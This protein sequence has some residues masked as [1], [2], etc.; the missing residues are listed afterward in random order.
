MRKPVAKRSKW[1]RI[2]AVSLVL[3]MAA[4]AGTAAY[5]YRLLTHRVV[6]SFFDSAGARIHYTD[7]GKG[8][9]VILLHGFAVHSDINWRHPGVIAELSK[10]FRVISMDLR[11]HG[12]S[13][14]PHEPAQYGVNLAEDVIRLMD[15]VGVANAHVVGYSLGGFVALKVAV[16]HPDRV[17]TVSPLGAGWETAD[18]STFL[19]SL[20]ELEASLRTGRGI[21][22][23]SGSLGPNRAKPG[24]L[25]TLFVK[26]MTR[27]FADSQALSALVSTVPALT[28]AEDELRAIQVPVCSIIGSDDPLKPGVDAMVGKVSDHTVIVLG[29]VDHLRAPSS[30]ELRARL[31]EFLERHPPGGQG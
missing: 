12:L 3:L 2:T 14:K 8:V 4:A 11:G 21:A 22:P 18:S 29:G 24:P 10:H 26:I 15:H 7:E 23:L 20:P 30:P 19:R 31:V 16:L 6:G 1:I 13:G 27:Y 9:P 28:I 25:H 5:G 17:I